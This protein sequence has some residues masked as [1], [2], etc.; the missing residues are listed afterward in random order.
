MSGWLDLRRAAEYTSLSVRTLRRY[1]GDAHH[2]LPVR[3]V[4]GKW[5]TNASLL[6]RWIQGFPAG[7]EDIDRF[8]DEVIHDVMKGTHHG[9]KR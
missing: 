7:K 6:D 3:I 2:P 9:Q 5:L 8:V 4:G 1:I